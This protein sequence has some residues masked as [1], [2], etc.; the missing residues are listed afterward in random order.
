V[1]P[2][3]FIVCLL[4]LGLT[5]CGGGGGDGL[6]QRS[7]SSLLGDLDTIESRLAGGGVE[8]CESVVSESIPALQAGIDGLSA[9]VDSSLRQA[10][11]DSTDRLRTLA[12]QECDERRRQA[13]QEQETETTPEPPTTETTPEPPTTETTPEP[14]TTE[15][16]PEPDK[17]DEKQDDAKDKG[18]GKNDDGGKNKGG[19]GGSAPGG[20]DPGAGQGGG[21]SPGTVLPGE[22]P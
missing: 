19:S 14:P 15:T 11:Q 5:A 3:A 21:T 12:E 10:L 22:A 6:S 13:E 1:R 16:T 17:G 7:A 20:G 4:A 2:L 9:D 18:K 8:T